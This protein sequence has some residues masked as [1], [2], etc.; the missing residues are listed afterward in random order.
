MKATDSAI[1]PLKNSQFWL[2]GI[3]GGLIAILLTL[4]WRTGDD[5]YLGMSVLCLFAIASTLV[6]KRHKLTLESGI[7]PSILGIMFI[8]FILWQSA[9]LHHGKW[10]KTFLHISP[11]I[12]AIGLS[13]LA[14]G[15]KGFKQFWQEL[16]IL[17]FLGVPKVT[18]LS[19]I[20]ITP[21]ATLT[22]KYSTLILW[23][24]GFEVSLQDNYIN[25][26]TGGIKVAGECAGLEWMCHL[27]SLAVIGLFMFPPK[28]KRR[29]LVPIVA[30]FVAFLVNGARIAILAVMAAKQH[31]PTFHYWHVGGGSSVFGII[32]VLIFGLFYW[33]LLHEQEIKKQNI[34]ESSSQ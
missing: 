25:L 12:S 3:G 22:A 5:S 18:I 9:N 14:S 7:F 2:L 19:L 15:L 23:Y 21:L 16:T 11:F 28:P 29:I 27:L 17:F 33:F 4:V 30:V 13:L 26:P 34:A 32:T 8:G 1:Q 31:Q 24:T 6:E 10:L 20:D